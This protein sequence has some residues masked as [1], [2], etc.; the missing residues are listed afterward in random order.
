ME[1]WDARDREV[2]IQVLRSIR[3]IVRKISEH[4]KHLSRD[5]GLTLPQLLCLRAIGKATQEEP[6]AAVTVVQ[7]AQLVQLSP[8][9]VS[10]IIDRLERAG[11]V[12]RER[13]AQDRRK[14]RLN[15]TP[16]G[17]E[18]YETLPVGLQERFLERL[19]KLPSDEREQL[20]RA[21]R[22]VTDMME[23]TDLDAAPMLAPET[24]VKD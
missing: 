9:T 14:V 22:K 5:L 11:L 7:V 15:L 19:D 4:S 3:Q 18:R 20:L 10:R 6:N 17:L 12:T 21:L 24:D 13:M 1:A 2:A 16:R 8:A 23:A